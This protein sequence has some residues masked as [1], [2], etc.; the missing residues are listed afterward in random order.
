MSIPIHHVGGPEHG[1]PTL[2]LA[3]GMADSW[4][5]WRHLAARLPGDW[6]LLAAELPWRAGGGHDWHRGGTPG[7][8]LADAVRSLPDPPD[9]I[10]G[11]SLGAN[12]VLDL[13]ATESDVAPRGAMLVAPFY[14]PPD[15]TVDWAV[16]ERCRAN[17]VLIIAEGLTARLGPRAADLDPDV[18]GAMLDKMVDRIGP[19]GFARLFDEFAATARL[20]L[21][22][23]AVPTAVLAGGRDPGMD[24]PRSIALRAHLPGAEVLVEPDLHHFCHLTQADAV[25]AHIAD[26]VGKVCTQPA[27]RGGTS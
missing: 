12:A 5:S 9:V 23:V 6:R 20:P 3:H 2:L 14:C 8:W 11:H 21:H 16:F 17:F 24:G 15:L 4:E 27:L 1:R 18:R 22:R 19:V 10:V 26:F 25:A 7:R 13:L